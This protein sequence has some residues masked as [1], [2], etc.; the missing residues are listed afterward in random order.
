MC[1]DVCVCAPHTHAHRGTGFPSMC[2]MARA[3]CLYI[4]HSGKLL[5]GNK[6]HPAWPQDTGCWNWWF[7]LHC[8]LL[9]YLSSWVLSVLMFFD[10]RPSL[11]PSK[12]PGKDVGPCCQKGLRWMGHRA[13]CVGFSS[14]MLWLCSQFTVRRPALLSRADVAPR[15][16]HSS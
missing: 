11:L 7:C 15:P 6:E 10:K 9:L 16:R 12:S 8:I 4:P 3:L 2:S 13:G 14:L 1:S 5:P